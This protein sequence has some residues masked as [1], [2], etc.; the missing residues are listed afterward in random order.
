MRAALT[1]MWR[2]ASFFSRTFG[3][4]EDVYDKTQQKLIKCATMSA[5]PAN[6]PALSISTLPADPE[7]CTFKFDKKTFE[8]GT[9]YEP[10]VAELRAAVARLL[11]DSATRSALEE[12][13]KA[14]M[15]SRDGRVIRVR[16]IVGE[17][18]SMHSEA[19]YAGAVFQAAS[20]FNYLEF[21]SPSCTPEHGIGQYE[22]D[23]TQGPACAIACAAGTAYRNYLLPPMKADVAQHGR[24]QRK[25]YQRNGL[26]ELT[27]QLMREMQQNPTEL[28]V[29]DSC[30]ML[31]RG[32]S[33][34][35]SSGALAREP[36]LDVTKPAIKPPWLVKHG[37][38]ESSPER[39]ASANALLKATAVRDRL[40]PLL[41][42]GIQ[43]DTDVIN[44]NATVP[45]RVT[46]V[47]CSAVSC[48]YSRCPTEAWAPLATLVLEGTYEATFLA[49]TYNAIHDILNRREPAPLLLT[50]VGGGVFGN[51]AR[52]IQSAMKRSVDAT[53][54]FGVPLD[55]LV[56]HYGSI[57]AEYENK[58]VN[59]WSV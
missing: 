8:A 50:K 20:Q 12:Y 48:G 37:Y 35:G 54:P 23:K 7:R 29:G 9:F 10:S 1:N 55:V 36:T 45:H 40:R 26:S 57:E 42:V 33:D 34:A 27:A 5:P 44:G 41:R 31:P 24:G 15:E 51:S 56:V 19:A 25:D 59:A 52:W 30:D 3:F 6:C 21:P 11:S 46:Q 32:N 47:Y 4:D 28:P 17:S 43:H 14:V 2:S 16:S 13:R 22:H 49:A 58:V 38:I 53:A 18:R 39:L